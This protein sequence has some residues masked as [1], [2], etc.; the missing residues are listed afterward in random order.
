M[1]PGRNDLTSACYNGVE[2]LGSLRVPDQMTDVGVGCPERVKGIEP[3]HGGY[4]NQRVRIYDQNR[5]APTVAHFVAQVTC[6]IS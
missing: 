2:E 3:R 6:R 1:P 5:V 4:K